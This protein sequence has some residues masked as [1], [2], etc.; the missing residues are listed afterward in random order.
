MVTLASCNEHHIKRNHK[1][2][3]ASGELI[4]DNA[5]KGKQME[6]GGMYTWVKALHTFRKN[7]KMV[8]VVRKWGR[9]DEGW[10]QPRKGVKEMG[11]LDW[12]R[13]QWEPWKW[14]D[15]KDLKKKEIEVETLVKDIQIGDG[16][17]VEE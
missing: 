3:E 9:N 16:F 2:K 14:M 5:D 6:D 10:S 7:V 1:S 17:E 4:S 8:I 13:E 15:T 11:D 12:G